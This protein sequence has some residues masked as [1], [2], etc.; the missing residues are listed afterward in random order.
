MFLFCLG[1]KIV[2]IVRPAQV[3]R[4]FHFFEKCEKNKIL[5]KLFLQFSLVCKIITKRDKNKLESQML[6]FWYV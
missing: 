1:V 3:L 4:C 6:L 2:V 5:K